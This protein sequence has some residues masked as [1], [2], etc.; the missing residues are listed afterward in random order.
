MSFG[1]MAAMLAILR[2]QTAEPEF[3]KWRVQNKLQRRRTLRTA[4]YSDVSA[5][6]PCRPGIAGQFFTYELCCSDAKDPHLSFL[7][8]LNAVKR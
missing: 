8:L 1:L 5:I 7:I 4:N 3:Y 6:W 2:L